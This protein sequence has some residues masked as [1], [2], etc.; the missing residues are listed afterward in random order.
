MNRKP[1]VR[2]ELF[3]PPLKMAQPDIESSFREYDSICTITSG[4][5]GSAHDPD[6]VRVHRHDSLHYIENDPSGLGQGNAGDYRMKHLNMP[7]MEAI[8]DDV[9]RRLGA[10]FDVVLEIVDKMGNPRNHLHVEYQPKR[11]P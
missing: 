11:K 5:E 2:C 6:G 7:T 9:K 8:R 10:D 3:S 1:E 4:H